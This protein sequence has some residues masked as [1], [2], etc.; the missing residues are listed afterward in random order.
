MITSLL[1]ICHRP[2][3]FWLQKDIYIYNVNKTFDKSQKKI[4]K[5]GNQRFSWYKEQSTLLIWIFYNAMNWKSFAK[6]CEK[7]P[8]I[9]SWET[10][11]DYFSSL[12]LF[13]TT[14]TRGYELIKFLW[15]FIILGLRAA[16]NKLT[17]IIARILYKIIL[18][19]LC[20]VPIGMA[21]SSL[22]RYNNL[23]NNFQYNNTSIIMRAL[24]VLMMCKIRKFYVF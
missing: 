6:V 9:F 10:P 11:E 4:Q 19:V 7:L 5:I 14:L 18:H 24:M 22:V 3:L 8:Q 13:E 17:R 23:Q 1:Q 15:W 2:K 16:N 12:K 20:C 21:L